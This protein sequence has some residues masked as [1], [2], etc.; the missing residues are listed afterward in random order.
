MSEEWAGGQPEVHT[1]KVH[2]VCR[3]WPTGSNAPVSNRKS[4]SLNTVQTSGRDERCIAIVASVSKYIVNC[5]RAKRI[6]RRALRPTHDDMLERCPSHIG[7][8]TSRKTDDIDEAS[9]VFS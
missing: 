5:L 2:A 4:N 1:R 7:D 8:S 9:T 3:N 6:R